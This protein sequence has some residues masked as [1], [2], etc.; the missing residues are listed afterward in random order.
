M[1]LVFGFQI[2]LVDKRAEPLRLDAAAQIDHHAASAH[3]R[4]GN[5]PFLAAPRKA[6]V[7]RKL[8]SGMIA[9]T[10]PPEAALE[11]HRPFAGRFGRGRFFP[12]AAEGG[13]VKIGLQGVD[14]DPGRGHRLERQRAQPVEHGILFVGRR[15]VAQERVELRLVPLPGLLEGRGI[16]AGEQQPQEILEIRGDGMHGIGRAVHRADGEHR[17]SKAAHEAEVDAVHAGPCE[18]PRAF[19]RAVVSVIA[20][21]RQRAERRQIDSGFEKLRIRNSHE[22]RLLCR[23]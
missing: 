11:I 1:Q 12:G 7:E 2:P 15:V 19:G 8:S 21:G 22:K 5:E 23:D 18:Y 20:I 4:G 6:P 9:A 17:L 16:A 10:M 14:V 3:I 13:I